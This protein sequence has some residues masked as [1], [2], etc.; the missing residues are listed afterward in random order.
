MNLEDLTPRLVPWLVPPPMDPGAPSPA[1]HWDERRLLCAYYT[2]KTPQRTVAVLRFEV[3]LEFRLGHPSDEALSGHPLFKY[4]LE[5]YGSYLVENSPLVAEIENRNRVHP[6]FRPGMYRDFGHW[7][8]TFH[9]ET[10]EVVALR[11]LVAGQSSLPPKSAV[12]E[13]VEDV[14]V[15][16]DC[17]DSRRSAL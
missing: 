14:R 10:L 17:S 4:G 13:Y 15:L 6:A 9:D 12:C 16:V 5:P 1:V 11:A 7:I 3:V 2:S 8:V